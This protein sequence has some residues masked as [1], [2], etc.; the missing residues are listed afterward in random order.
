MAVSWGQQMTC[1]VAHNFPYTRIEIRSVWLPRQPARL[2]PS[3]MLLK[4]LACTKG[5]SRIGISHSHPSC[6][7]RGRRL[8]A[9]PRITNGRNLVTSR[10]FTSPIYPPPLHI[11]WITACAT[12][13]HL[14][15][16]VPGRIFTDKHVSGVICNGRRRTARSIL[17]PLLL[18]L[19]YLHSLDGGE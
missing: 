13:P 18:V 12:I 15:V 19:P 11:L 3:R 7:Q 9:R 8:R 4:H 5:N 10:R 14:E 6:V 2:F 1:L 17:V 16:F